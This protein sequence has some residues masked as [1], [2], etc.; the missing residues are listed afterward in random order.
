MRLN[1]SNSFT[2]VYVYISLDVHFYLSLPIR[3]FSK[4]LFY[5]FISSFKC[6][7]IYKMTKFYTDDIRNR[8]DIIYIFIYMEF[9]H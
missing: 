8:L 7:L 2:H 5:N 3:Y 9:R 4:I 6:H 1:R